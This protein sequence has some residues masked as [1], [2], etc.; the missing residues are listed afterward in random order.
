MPRD[1][2]AS[3]DGDSLKA[4]LSFLWTCLIFAVAE[5]TTLW[6]NSPMNVHDKDEEI[7]YA[8]DV[9]DAVPELVAARFIL[10]VRPHCQKPDLLNITRRLPA[11]DKRVEGWFNDWK[12]RIDRLADFIERMER[13]KDIP[14]E[15]IQVK[16]TLKAGSL[17]LND[18]LGVTALAAMGDNQKCY[19]VDFSRSEEENPRN[20]LRV[21]FAEQVKGLVLPAIAK[22]PGWRSPEW[23]VSDS[24]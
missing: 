22:E 8:C 12:L 5:V 11:W 7:E 17:V 24:D 3:P 21:F 6:A 4:G 16:S 13:A 14:V 20:A 2:F 9:W 15:S 10:A 18:A 1:T 19:L 23:L